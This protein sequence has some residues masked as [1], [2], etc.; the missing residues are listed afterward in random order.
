MN[1][2]FALRKPC[3]NCPFRNDDKAIALQPGRRE[4]ILEG[5]LSGAHETFSCHKTVFRD[6]GRNHDEDGRYRPVDVSR[7][8]GCRQNISVSI[9]PKLGYKKLFA[10]GSSPLNWL[11]ADLH[12]RHRAIHHGEGPLVD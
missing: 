6:D 12:Q 9:E 5:L 2:Q 7:R 11:A 3:A 1:N 8:G 4:E 10:A